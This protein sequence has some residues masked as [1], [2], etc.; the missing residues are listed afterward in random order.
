MKAPKCRLC[1][2]EHGHSEPHQWGKEADEGVSHADFEVRGLVLEML[3]RMVAVEAQ[4]ALLTDKVNKLTEVNEPV[5]TPDVNAETSAVNSE[6]NRAA[7]MREYMR[8]KRAKV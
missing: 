8:A 5:Y 2:H 1:H 7:Y 4:V 6:T 3:G